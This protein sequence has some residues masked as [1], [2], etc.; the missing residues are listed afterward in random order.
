MKLEAVLLSQIIPVSSFER[1]LQRG[2]EYKTC[3]IHLKRSAG[4]PLRWLRMHQHLRSCES[5]NKLNECMGNVSR[6]ALGVSWDENISSKRVS[7]IHAE[8]RETRIK[9]FPNLIKISFCWIK[10]SCKMEISAIKFYF[11]DR[12]SVFFRGP[13]TE[14]RWTLLC[15]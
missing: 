6:L 4:Y 3:E 11:G 9:S 14:T 10:V 7:A 8:G 2:G 12:T 5:F 1:N 15:V 13:N